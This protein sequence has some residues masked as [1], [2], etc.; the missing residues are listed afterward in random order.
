MNL[1]RKYEKVVKKL[2][3]RKN[4]VEMCIIFATFAA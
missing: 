2:L 4:G 1:L 3:I